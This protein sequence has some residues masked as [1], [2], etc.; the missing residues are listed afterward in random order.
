MM[1]IGIGR[2]KPSR[3]RDWENFCR[4]CGIAEW[5]LF[6]NVVI[7][8]QYVLSGSE[9]KYIDTPVFKNVANLKLFIKYMWLIFS[10][11]KET[12]W[13]TLNRPCWL[14]KLAVCSRNVIIHSRSDHTMRETWDELS[15]KKRPVWNSYEMH[16]QKS[17]TSVKI[18]GSS[19]QRLF[20]LILSKYCVFPTQRANVT[21]TCHQWSVFANVNYCNQKKRLCGR[22]IYKKQNYL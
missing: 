4:D 22:P 7:S 10:H 16:N 15:H 19:N 5:R 8:I 3:L 6:F 1:G 20:Y 2:Y 18:H 12:R 13:R 9:Y 17:K 14:K 11:Q 21:T